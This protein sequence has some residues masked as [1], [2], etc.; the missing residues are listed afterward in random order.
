MLSST[1]NACHSQTLM[2]CCVCF[3]PTDPHALA[4]QMVPGELLTSLEY[5]TSEQ[6][7]CK[8][9]ALPLRLRT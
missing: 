7:T 9:V 5:D 8:A 2:P 4:T 6:Y 3:E 1:G